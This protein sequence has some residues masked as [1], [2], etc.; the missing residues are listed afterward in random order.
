MNTAGKIIAGAVTAAAIGGGTLVMTNL[1]EPETP[2][3][4]D[5]TAATVEVPKVEVPKVELPTVAVPE[6]AAPEITGVKV[7]AADV[8]MYHLPVSSDLSDVSVLTTS[9][10]SAGVSTAGVSSANVAIPLIAMASDRIPKL[11][12]MFQEASQISDQRN[13]R[14]DPEFGLDSEAWKKWLAIYRKNEP[15]TP[16]YK[17]LPADLRIIAEVKCPVGEDQVSTLER[18]LDFYGKQ[19]YNAVLLTFDTSEDLDR[20]ADTA[21]LIRAH[22]MKI[23]CAYSGPEKLNWSVY[24]DPDLIEKFVSR[25]CARSDA[26]L[27]GWR[28]TSSH[29][30][31]M[32]EPFRNHLLRAARKLN[33]EIAVIGE[34]FCGR[35]A[36][37]PHTVA[38]NVPANASAV[39]LFGIGYR[40]VAIE[41]AMNGVFDRVRDL[42]RIGL[43]IGEK[44]YY[45]TQHDT[46]RT[47]AENL[48]IKQRIE[49][50]FRSG[51]CV[52]TLTIRGDGS[53][54]IYNSKFTENLSLNYGKEETK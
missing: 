52:G 48:K 26:Y 21:D 4:D 39:L 33:P 9:V 14:H 28:R 3:V 31:L 19:G 27:I 35:T 1:T 49:R 10:Q 45:D 13:L 41:P 17:P 23:V 34:A 11:Q 50:R 2:V 46:G 15:Y 24:R 7:L 22:G 43:S 30:L 20:L 42:P 29:L 47:F 53:D 40:G 25:I 37:S 38:Y 44:P 5:V 16:E 51:G 32:D 8:E 12:R 18:N 54:G 36:E 6:V